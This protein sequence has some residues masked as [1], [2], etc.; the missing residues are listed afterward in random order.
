MPLLRR[1]GKED[2]IKMYN[3]QIRSSVPKT[4]VHTG[5]YPREKSRVGSIVG[6]HYHDELEFI[7]VYEGSFAVTVDG[8]EYFAEGGDVVFIGSGV[9][10]STRYVLPS[11]TGLIQ[12]RENDFLSSSITKIIKYSV[13]FSNLSESKI[14]II[15]NKEL[16]DSLD[17]LLLESDSKEGA[18][19]MFVRSEVYRIL[20]ILYREGILLDTERFFLSKEIQKILPA[21][22]YINK[23]YHENVSLEDASTILG[24]DTS[25][26]CRIFKSA[27]GSTFTEYLNFVRVCKAERLLSETSKSILEISEAVGF[28]SI[29]YFNRVFRKIRNTS[30]GNYRLAEYVNI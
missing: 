7:I 5:T 23:N 17:R 26:F 28:S 30:P 12:F 25:Y 21:L 22:E 18:F 9:P 20:G 11:R 15:K 8:E 19:E 16:F 13:K 1:R 14:R 2:K 4:P 6:L 3:E 24:F 10:H 27:T 29:S